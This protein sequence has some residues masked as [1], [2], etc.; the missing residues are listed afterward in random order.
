M[1]SEDITAVDGP[2]RGI[3]SYCPKCGK[4]EKKALRR[5]KSFQ[6]A[7]FIAGHVERRL[8]CGSCGYAAMQV[9]TYGFQTEN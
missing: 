1:G 8:R 2:P 3:E 7:Q 5:T 4:R 9:Y 6:T